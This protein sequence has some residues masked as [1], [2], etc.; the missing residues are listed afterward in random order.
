VAR[1]PD[2][3]TLVLVLL[4]ST[5]GSPARLHGVVARASGCHRHVFAITE[6]PA[7]QG[8]GPSDPGVT[9]RPENRGTAPVCVDRTGGVG[10]GLLRHA[11][12]LW[13]FP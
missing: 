8:E 6:R 5:L 9:P 12:S 1:R 11:R 4:P 13:G 3:R 2:Q 10:S 7:M